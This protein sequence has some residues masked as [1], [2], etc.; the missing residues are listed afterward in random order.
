MRDTL[1]RIAVGLVVVTIA[2][3]G[4]IAA[5][6]AADRNNL[7]LELSRVLERERACVLQLGSKSSR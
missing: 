7:R 5:G 6:A 3:L 4:F 1:I 2:V